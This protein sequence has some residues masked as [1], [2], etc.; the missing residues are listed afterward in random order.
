[1]GYIGQ[2]LFTHGI[3]LFLLL[4]ILLQLIIGCLQLRNSLLQGGGHP[5]EIMPQSPDLIV[6]STGIPGL[7]SR[8]AI[9][10]E[11]RV[12]SVRGR[13]ILLAKRLANPT[14]SAAIIPPMNR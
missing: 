7:K 12:S 4:N 1:M 6:A 11:I 13:V 3:D 9:R 14:P 10:W 2:E 8:L 5:V